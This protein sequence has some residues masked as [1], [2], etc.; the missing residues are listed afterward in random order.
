MGREINPLNNITVMDNPSAQD[1]IIDPCI[2]KGL[3]AVAFLLILAN[4]MWIFI[5]P[6]IDSLTGLLG[7]VAIQFDL[8]GE[9]N[10]A[11]WYSVTLLLFNSLLAYRQ[12]CRYRQSHTRIARTYV[13]LSA[14]FLAL[15]IDDFISFHEFVEISAKKQGLNLQAGSGL[16]DYSGL[17]F[18][19]LLGLTLLFLVSG[20]FFRHARK[21]NRVFIILS[22]VLL[23]VSVLSESIYNAFHWFDLIRGFRIEIAIDESC[24]LGAILSFLI[25]QQRESKKTPPRKLHMED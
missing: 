17:V 4:I 16:S 22:L 3:V 20:A 1:S 10:F 13:I 15:S 5:A 9:R 25:F 6:E 2:L 24:E 14:G 18:G 21:E 8:V 19:I 7:E 11:T 12:S 23:L